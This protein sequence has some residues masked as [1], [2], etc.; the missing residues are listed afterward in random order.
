[1]EYFLAV[2]EVRSINRAAQDAFISHQALSK[3]VQGIETELGVELFARSTNGLVPTKAGE[4]FYRYGASSVEAYRTMLR[5]IRELQSDKNILHI[6]TAHICPFIL[7]VGEILNFEN[8]QSTYT[9][10]HACRG[11]KAC[12]ERLDSGETD[13]AFCM[14]PADTQRYVAHCLKGEYACVVASDQSPFAQKDEV[15]TRDLY[16]QLLLTP[17]DYAANGWPISEIFPEGHA[18]PAMRV[19]DN[20]GATMVSLVRGNRGYTIVSQ[21]GACDMV[22]K[23]KGLVMRRI[24]ADRPVFKLCMVVRRDRVDEAGISAFIEYCLENLD[25]LLLATD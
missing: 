6:D 2:Y 8:A 3:R 24:H 9:L 19:L 16:R 18:L 15:S 1:M 4:L 11:G 10:D 22:E 13:V 25:T 20:D 14:P 7:D 12:Y 17:T 5:G 23:N 21:G